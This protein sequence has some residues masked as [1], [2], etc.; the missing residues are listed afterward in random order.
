MPLP[1]YRYC[2]RFAPSPTGPLH[3]GSLVAA[4]AGYLDARAQGGTWLL[5]IEDLDTARN[6]PD[7]EDSIVRTLEHAALHWDGPI[8][9]QSSRIEHYE[10]PLAQ[11]RRAGLLYPC[12][13][14]RREIADSLVGL[15]PSGE[16]RYSGAC[17]ARAWDSQ[18]PRPPAWRIRTAPLPIA[19]EDRLHGRF[20]TP[21]LESATGDF[22]L[23][24]ADGVIAYQLAVVVD[25]AAFGITDVVRG[26]DLLGSTFRQ[27]FL[28]HTLGLPTPSYL[29][30]PTATNARGEKLSKQTLAA[31]V[32]G[33]NPGPALWL[34]LRFLGQQPPAELRL[35]PPRELLAWAVPHWRAGS[36]PR[37]Q[38]A[39]CENV[40]PLH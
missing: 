33:Q 30:V 7:A 13:C 8:T 2:G 23:R 5:R 31:P 24:R 28:Q 36:I 17:R 4:L 10:A 6:R 20:E 29:H 21:D 25:D 40:E 18:F 35:A 11:L 1:G 39:S 19:F 32:D 26:A 34:A 9:H 15:S 12:I 14:S 37:L 16:A 22:I 27:I 3:F 38:S